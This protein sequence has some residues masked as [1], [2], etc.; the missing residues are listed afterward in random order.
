MNRQKPGVIAERVV[1]ERKVEINKVFFLNEHR[2]RLSYLIIPIKLSHIMLKE[3]KC[4]CMST[5]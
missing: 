4:T 5:I 1:A 2:L 3:S